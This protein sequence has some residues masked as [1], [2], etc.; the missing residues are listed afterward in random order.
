MHTHA[1]SVSTKEAYMLIYYYYSFTFTNT[2]YYCC[3][4]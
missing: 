2:I 4:F 3:I 1:Q